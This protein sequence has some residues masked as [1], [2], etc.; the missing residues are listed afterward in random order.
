MRRVGFHSGA[1]GG[2]R[3]RVEKATRQAA[4]AAWFKPKRERERA[5]GGRECERSDSMLCALLLRSNPPEKRRSARSPSPRLR[6]R[7]RIGPSDRVEASQTPQSRRRGGSRKKGEQRR[8]A[9]DWPQRPVSHGPRAPSRA[10]AVPFPALT[11]TVRDTQ[12]P[13]RP[14]W[15]ASQAPFPLSAVPPPLLFRCLRSPSLFQLTAAARTVAARGGGAWTGDA[16]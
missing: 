4:G 13:S 15:P 16:A 11:G 8:R 5:A 3:G 10:C 14:I 1:G 9:E 6:Q 7:P 2:G 12:F